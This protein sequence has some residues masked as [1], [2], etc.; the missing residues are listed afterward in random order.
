MAPG[1][2]PVKPD[3]LINREDGRKYWENAAA[4]VDG[5]LG[6]TE[7]LFGPVTRVDLQGSRTFLARLGLS[8]SRN[9]PKVENC[10]EGGAG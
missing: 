7:A 10:L 3:S 1:A 5:M 9:G 4:D 8:S 6:G 2:E